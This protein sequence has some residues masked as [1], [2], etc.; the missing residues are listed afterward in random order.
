MQARRRNH[1]GR[2]KRVC[3]KALVHLRPHSIP[4]KGEQRH[5]SS[6][7][8]LL[9]IL[10]TTGEVCTLG[11]KGAFPSA[12]R[13]DVRGWEEQKSH[14]EEIQPVLIY[15]SRSS[16]HSLPQLQNKDSR[17]KPLC[18]YRRACSQ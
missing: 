13:I 1:G 14:L 16:L 12:A 4:K 9:I 17:H 18:I 5:F 11:L 6:L 10:P 2:G 15:L 7:L 8:H 3:I